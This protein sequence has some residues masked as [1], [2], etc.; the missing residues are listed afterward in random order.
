MNPIL[1]DFPDS[2][3]TER[4][5]IRAHRV[6]DGA[7]I[8]EAV[9]ESLDALRPWMPWAQDEPSA[10]A[11]E[12]RIRH[13]I[14]GWIGRKDLGLLLFLKGRDTLVGSSGLHRIDWDARCFE[15]GYW[16]RTKFA[17]QGYATEAVN[18]ITRFAF[19]HLKANRVEIR[20]DAKNVRSAAIA[21][22][23]GFLLEGVRRHDSL[24][25]DG[26]LRDTLVFS[27]IG[28]DEFHWYD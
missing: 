4:L 21:K 23:C 24:G 17:G 18:G 9:R 25:V 27:K 10:E 20:C 16:V 13:C 7:Q 2:F 8:A 26:D 28:L 22:R 14:A 1:L 12:A 19:T 15:I 11:Q 6:G 5:T 3:D